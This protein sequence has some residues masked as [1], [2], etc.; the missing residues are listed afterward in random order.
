MTK[1]EFF[2]KLAELYA[3]A[4]ASDSDGEARE[5]WTHHT[6]AGN[7]FCRKIDEAMREME[8]V[9]VITRAERDT[10]YNGL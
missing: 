6:M 10:F 4:N 8:Y 7:G 3:V 1:V 5:D 2:A 9:G